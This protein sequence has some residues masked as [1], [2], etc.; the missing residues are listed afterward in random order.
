[1]WDATTTNRQPAPT[2]RRYWRIGLAGMLAGSA[3]AA[4][5][6]AW[7][8]NI[9]W[10]QRSVVAEIARFDARIVYDYQARGAS[11]PP[12]PNWLLRIF[13]DDFLT[14]VVGI[15]INAECVDETAVAAIASLPH[16]KFLLLRAQGMSD[17]GIVQFAAMKELD[18]L[19]FQSSTVTDAGLGQLTGIKRL[20]YLSIIAPEVTDTGLILL[21]EM[22]NLTFV[23]L[24][25]TAVTAEG[26][27]Q[28]RAAL[29][30]CD[31]HVY[32]EPRHRL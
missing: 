13:G 11:R 5:L 31:V 26:V 12:G 10:H 32:P 29:P 25:S 9:V 21:A 23:E 16:L 15:E 17:Q 7:Q 14:K 28:L 3:V 4:I 18:Q 27:D 6:V 2:R 20:S 30:Q 1:M 19:T 24:I 22:P 8:A